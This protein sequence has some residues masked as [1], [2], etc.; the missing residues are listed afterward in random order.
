M[1]K[2]FLTVA[3][4]L[5][6]TFAFATNAEEKVSVF[7]I[8]ETFEGTN[9][10]G[11]TTFDFTTENYSITKAVNSALGCLL[12]ITVEYTDGSSDTFYIY[13]VNMSCKEFFDLLEK[14]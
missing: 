4:V 2:I 6:V 5:T 13:V 14:E 9:L 3:L 10:L 8:E 1:K 7:N 11:L 12:T